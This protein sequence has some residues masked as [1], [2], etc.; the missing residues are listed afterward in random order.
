M[1]HSILH[2][3]FAFYIIHKI[4]YLIVLLLQEFAKYRLRLIYIKCDQVIKNYTLFNFNMEAEI[5]S[6]RRN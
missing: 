1:D 4:L 6:S 3:C 2:Q 5:Q